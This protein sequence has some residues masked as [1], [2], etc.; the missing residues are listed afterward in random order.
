MNRPQMRLSHTLV[1]AILL[2]FV[3]SSAVFAQVNYTLTGTL[4]LTSA[5]AVPWASIQVS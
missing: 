5:P 3:S 4:V 1:I 2:F